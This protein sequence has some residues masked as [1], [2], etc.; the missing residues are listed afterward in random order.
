MS[1]IL[2]RGGSVEWLSSSGD[3]VI[4]LCDII[5]ITFILLMHPKNILKFEKEEVIKDPKQPIFN[6]ATL[7]QDLQI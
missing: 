2:R 7:K 5:F 1:L 6:Y 4:L 3:R